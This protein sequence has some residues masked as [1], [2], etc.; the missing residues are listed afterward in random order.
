[1]VSTCRDTVCGPPSSRL[2]R[3]ALTW[4]PLL[5]TQSREG[6]KGTSHSP[7][8]TTRLRLLCQAA[9]PVSGSEY[10]RSDRLRQPNSRARGRRSAQSSSATRARYSE[11]LSGLSHAS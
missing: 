7:G 8:A 1:M 11:T 2:S 5:T 10:T 6:L 9:R 3:R 4:L